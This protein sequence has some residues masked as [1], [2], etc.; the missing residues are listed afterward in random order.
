MHLLMS[1]KVLLF[2]DEVGFESKKNELENQ[3][4]IQFILNANTEY[5]TNFWHN[6]SINHN[7]EGP[8]PAF[9]FT[10]SQR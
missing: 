3:M 4:D 2:F 1:M 6:S 10:L 7:G 9:A 5:E 8:L